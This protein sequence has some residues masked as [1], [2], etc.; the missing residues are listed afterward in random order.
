M[1]P[2]EDHPGESEQIATSFWESLSSISAAALPVEDDA[3]RM[4]LVDV[5]EEFS[6]IFV[7]GS[8]F[9]HFDEIRE[10]PGGT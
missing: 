4:N 7:V 3:V 8:A 9:K 6:I 5:F 10:I 1:S 2:V